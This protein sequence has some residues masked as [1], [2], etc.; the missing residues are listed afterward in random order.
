M[1]V[2]RS[3]NKVDVPP[4]TAPYKR[5]GTPVAA[6][7]K[8]QLKAQEGTFFSDLSE[9]Y[10][11]SAGAK[12]YFP[13]L[14]SSPVTLELRLPGQATGDLLDRA[15][16]NVWTSEPIAK[17]HPCLGKFGAGKVHYYTLGRRRAAAV[18]FSRR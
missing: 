6:N 12:E 17:D 10:S 13:K 11:G 1:K 2:N 7:A 16:V 4:Y 14:G 5:T 3:T 8:I 15:V 9:E 18:G